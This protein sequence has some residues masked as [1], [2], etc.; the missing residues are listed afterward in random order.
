[1]TRN[2]RFNSRHQTH[3]H[4]TI[5]RSHDQHRPTNPKVKSC[6][7]DYSQ[8]EHQN[9]ITINA[10]PRDCAGTSLPPLIHPLTEMS[11]TP[12]IN[13]RIEKDHLQYFE[14][15]EQFSNQKV[16]NREP[17]RKFKQETD[18]MAPKETRAIAAKTK[19]LQSAETTLMRTL[20]NIKNDKV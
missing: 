15:I 18:K 12:P 9:Q 1:M 6:L 19:E 13:T 20:R 4:T 8:K 5:D 11:N 10:K 2:Q 16:E 3:R 7:H 14:E 17:I